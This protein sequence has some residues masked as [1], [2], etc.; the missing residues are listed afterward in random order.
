VEVNRIEEFHK[1]WILGNFSPSLVR[2]EKF[3]VGIKHFEKG[4]SEP[5]HF[6]LTATEITVVI[7]GT[8]SLSGQVFEPGDVISILPNEV[9]DFLSI[10]DSILVCIKFPSLPSDKVIVN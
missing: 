3:E 2:T 8:I 10:T 1:G 7:I 4:E 6:Q 5:A 9:A